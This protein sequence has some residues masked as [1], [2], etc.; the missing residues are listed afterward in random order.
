MRETDEENRE[1]VS[2]LRVHRALFIIAI[3]RP[4]RIASVA[5]VATLCFGDVD[6][7]ATILRT[8]IRFFCAY[9]F[10]RS[11]PTFAIQLCLSRGI[12]VADFYLEIHICECQ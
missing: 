9:I 11:R 8:Y 3:L 7:W 4:L 6:F 5:E 12:I 2:V 1:P 10:D